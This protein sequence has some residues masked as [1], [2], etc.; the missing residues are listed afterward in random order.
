MVDDARSG[1]L[2]SVRTVRTVRTAKERARGLFDF[3]TELGRVTV[4]ANVLAQA[5][6]TSFYA[7][8]ALG[9]LAL[10]TMSLAGFVFGDDAVRGEVFTQLTGVMGPNNAHFIED[11]VVR[12]AGARGQGAA[13]AIGALLFLWSAG[14]V[15]AQVREG[16]AM[17]GRVARRMP[18]R[19]IA[20]AEHAPMWKRVLLGGWSFVHGRLL[21]IAMVLII[22]LLLVASIVA[23]STLSVVTGMLP[24]LDAGRS[25]SLTNAAVSFLLLTSLSALL[26]GVLAV[27]RL[28]RKSAFVGGVVAALLFL[29]ARTFISTAVTYSAS[30]SEF[31]PAASVIAVLLWSWFTVTTLL[32]GCAAGAVHAERAR[33]QSERA[34]GRDGIARAS[35]PI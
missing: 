32:V 24:W 7:L 26:Y 18:E 23:T 17:V 20:H 15:F 10:V 28:P 4:D 22:A 2:A 27:P 5:A 11:M 19:V 21:S 13:A 1:P 31:G 25:V 14:G 35:A 3:V 34:A 29:V 9:P 16:L 6:A 30:E 33:A 12:S 8:L